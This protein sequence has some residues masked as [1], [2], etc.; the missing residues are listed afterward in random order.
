V[1]IVGE[2]DIKQG[3]ITDVYFTRTMEVLKSRGI[4]KWVRAEFI[5]KQFPGNIPWA[6]FAGLSELSEVVS[7][8]NVKM[9]AMREGTIIRTYEPVI[10]IEGMYTDFAVLETAMLGFI[11]QA[12]GIATK[13][14]RCKKAADG[15]PVIS[16]G[17][18][19]AHPAIAPMVERNAFIGGCD[20]VS[21]PYTAGL[22][23][24]A[25]SGTMPHALI[26][27]MGDTVEAARAFDEVIDPAVNRIALIDTFNDEKVEAVRVAEALKE[28]LY[29]VRFDTPQS[30]RGNLARILEETRWELAI[31][32][33]GHV[34]LYV[35]GGVDESQ[36]ADLN[37]YVDGYGVGTSISNARVLDFAMDIVE[38]D[39]KPVAKRGKM[40]GAKRVLRCASCC[41]DRVVSLAP[42]TENRC[43]CGG[44]FE[45]LLAPWYDKSGFLFEGESPQDIRRYVLEQLLSFGFDQ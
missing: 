19:R 34:K 5:V 16:F 4:D 31:R 23:G 1:L 28:R 21:V 38:I 6:V 17:A 33:L 14:A 2:N 42:P 32:G 27:M 3:K 40:S 35:S 18:R 25:P 24:E 15:R 41:Q 26:L 13:A 7:G 43:E 30:R 12:S 44:R 37:P 39:G 45:E 10:E 9:R 11:C 20:G 29:G 36:M 22:L 8:L